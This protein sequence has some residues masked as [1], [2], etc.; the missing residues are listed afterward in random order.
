MQGYTA[1][2]KFAKQREYLP[3]PMGILPAILNFMQHDG[4][5]TVLRLPGLNESGKVVFHIV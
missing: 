1:M 2:A 5:S 3:Y 4:T